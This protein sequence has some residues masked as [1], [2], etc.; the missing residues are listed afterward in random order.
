MTQSINNL[1]T[2]KENNPNLFGGILIVFILLLTFIGV[3]FQNSIANKKVIS[4]AAFTLG[5][6]TGDIK[7]G[8]KGTNGPWYI[9][10]YTVKGKIFYSFKPVHLCKELGEKLFIGKFP[11]IY[12]STNPNNSRVLVFPFEFE[13]LGIN[14]PDSLK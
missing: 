6:F 5:H 14:I 13:D 4:N 8:G 3:N 2:F 11:V 7:P 12:D 9:C 10:Q 1:K